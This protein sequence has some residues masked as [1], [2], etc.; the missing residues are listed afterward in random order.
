MKP[1]KAEARRQGGA[2]AEESGQNLEGA[3][4][5][6]EA[7]LANH[8]RTKAGHSELMEAVCERGNLMLAYQRVVKN[9]GAAGVDGRGL[10]A[11]ISLSCTPCW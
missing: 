3:E 8:R 6:A 1:E 11:W 4:W 2:P 9:K 5:R 7:E 10:P